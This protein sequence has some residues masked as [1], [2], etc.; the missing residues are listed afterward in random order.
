MTY[1][2]YGEIIQLAIYIRN[3]FNLQN[4]LIHKLSTFN[5]KEH[6][7]HFDSQKRILQIC[8]KLNTSTRSYELIFIQYPESLGVIYLLN[9][10]CRLSTKLLCIHFINTLKHNQALILIRLAGKNCIFYPPLPALMVRK[11]CCKINFVKHFP[12]CVR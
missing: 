5:F 3:S 8:L 11:F 10:L 2:I 4:I 12:S 7:Q 6:L 1:L 9:V